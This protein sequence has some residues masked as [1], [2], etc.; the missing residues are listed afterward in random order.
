MASNASTPSK[1]VEGALEVFVVTVTE[2]EGPGMQCD[3]DNQ[4]YAKTPILVG[5]F[6][7]QEAAVRAGRDW[8]KKNGLKDHDAFYQDY[9][10][11]NRNASRSFAVSVTKQM[12]TA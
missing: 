7:R 1:Q 11:V 4:Q 3:F 5:V 9:M 12:V 8:A 2:G 6:R 10:Y